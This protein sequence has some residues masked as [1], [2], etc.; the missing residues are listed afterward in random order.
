MLHRSVIRALCL[1]RSVTVFLCKIPVADRSL[2]HR[3]HRHPFFLNSVL[4][5]YDLLNTP[6]VI[7]N[8]EPCHSSRGYSSASHR[9]GPGSSLG[10]TMWDLWWTKWKG[11]GTK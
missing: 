6:R 3:P 5:I 1:V 7:L 11:A 4:F 8:F 2:D 9:G 10:Q